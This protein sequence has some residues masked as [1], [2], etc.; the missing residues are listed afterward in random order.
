MRLLTISILLLSNVALSQQSIF[1]HTITK[2][3]KGN[4]Q[5][6]EFNR[7]IPSPATAKDFF[8]EYLKLSSKDNFKEVTKKSKARDGNHIR[9]DQYYDDTKVDG[10]GFALHFAGGKMTLA[11]GKF[12]EIKDLKSTASITADEAARFFAKSL[13]IPFDAVTD[14]R[15][16]LI[17]KEMPNQVPMLVFKIALSAEN[18]NNNS[19][20]F[21]DANTGD[22]LMTEAKYSHVAATG[23]F[24]TR[25][26]GTKQSITESISGSFRLED[27]TRGAII[28]T[29]N[30][31][32]STNTSFRVSI[33]DNDNNWTAAE[34]SASEDDMSLDIH[35]GLQQIY[36]HLNSF[37]INSFDDNGF[38]V[39]AH[40]HFGSTSAQKDN[41]FWDLDKN[42]LVF[43]DGATILRPVASLDAIAHEFGHGISDLQMGW[44]LAGNLAAFH[45]GLSD[46]WG[47]IFE[48]RIKGVSS[49]N[50]KIGEQIALNNT[51]LRNIQNT[52]DAGAFLSISD[53]FMSSQYNGGDKYV[54]S[55]VFSHWFYVLVNG[56]SGVNDL[57]NS[58]NVSGLG[59]D[60]AEEILLFAVY[61]NFFDFVTTYPDIRTAII[62]VAIE[63]YC[64]NSPEVRS[65]TNA[66]HAV[67]VGSVFSGTIPSISGNDPICTTQNFTIQNQISGTTLFWSSGNTSQMSVSPQSSATTTASR[68]NSYNGAV[69][70]NVTLVGAA[71]CTTTITRAVQV[72][73]FNTGQVT[74]TG[75]TGVCNGN[76]YVYSAIVPGGH[77]TGYTYAWTKP[78]NWTLNYQSANTIS[79]YVPQYNPNYGTVRVS[80]YNGCGTTPH[81]GITVYPGSG[82]SG[83]GYYFTIFPN[84]STALITVELVQ[85]NAEVVADSEKEF[86]DLVYSIEL[87]NDNG[88]KMLTET[89]KSKIISFE[90]VN[91]PKGLYFLNI[92]LKNEII[93]ERVLIK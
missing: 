6:V 68:L 82:C 85:E 48:Y 64:N 38:A 61:N 57:G 78:A 69:D 16:E 74:V 91:F 1:K 92:I 51:S 34:Y 45:E 2:D 77:K 28:R 35:W 8:D 87:V 60:K 9:Y 90:T 83:G 62:N 18:P 75:Q 59:M 4:V 79:Y 31:N 25:Y 65:V 93:T 72:G 37:G 46:I 27:F 29:W 56:E 71:S 36:D 15:G 10:A 32:G 88:K 3:S 49:N 89:S 23:T 41:A 55:G 7:N 42:E 26:S 20:G 80:V 63:K 50:W 14:Y 40:I 21:I 76:N 81:T 39:D 12:V 54:R 44:S 66:W 33:T 17:I 30:L 11:Q 58:Y 52:N 86:S 24:A 47:A 84:P 73:A 19:F 70:L 22:L 67:G 5:I 53:T 13:D 43:G